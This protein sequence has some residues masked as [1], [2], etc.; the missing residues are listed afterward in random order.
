[1]RFGIGLAMLL[2]LGLAACTSE[3]T[4]GR[5]AAEPTSY[6]P[7]AFAHRVAS[8]HVVLYWN[9]ARPDA[10]LVRL[11]G[12][13]Q[14]PWSPQEVRFLEFDL[15][16]VDARDRTVSQAKGE[17]RDFLLGTSQTT[18]FHLDL[19]TQGT[20]VRFDL[21]YRYRFQD[22]GRSFIAG[23]L[24]GAPPLLAQMQQQFFVRDVCSETQHRLQNPPQ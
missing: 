2:G 7:D 23:R 9:C 6:P 13:A 3:G 10:G 16:G 14:N 24:V 15:V 18:P 22:N 4:L 21:Y 17:A 11:E 1:M 8:S 19:R 5:P 12:V 20:E